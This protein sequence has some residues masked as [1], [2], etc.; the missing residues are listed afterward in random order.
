MMDNSL[1]TSNCQAIGESSN[2]YVQQEE[3]AGLKEEAGTKQ[4]TMTTNI[5]TN[6][7]NDDQ[8]I[9]TQVENIAASTTINKTI[10]ENSV[11][12]ELR[13][14]ESEAGKK[15]SKDHGGTIKLMQVR[16]NKF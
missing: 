16:L 6:K 9:I 2:K 7:E 4:T 14:C 10:N 3:R 15:P 12:S 5:E 11:T 13:D 8:E 1:P